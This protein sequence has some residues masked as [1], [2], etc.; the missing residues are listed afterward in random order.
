MSGFAVACDQRAE[1]RIRV[2]LDGLKVI[3]AHLIATRS[4]TSPRSSTPRGESH[5][6][7]SATASRRRGGGGCRTDRDP[8]PWAPAHSAAE[9][10]LR[11]AMQ[12]RSCRHRI[13]GGR[14]DEEPLG[15][16]SPGAGGADGV[17]S[18]AVG[19][20]ADGR[21]ATENT[22]HSPGETARAAAVECD[23]KLPAKA[24]GAKAS[25]SARLAD[26]RWVRAA[27]KGECIRAKTPP[28]G[29]EYCLLTC[30]AGCGAANGDQISW[31]RT[32]RAR[33]HRCRQP[34]PPGPG[35]RRGG[36]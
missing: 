5:P 11:Q 29:D 21:R 7:R 26:P 20:E 30:G 34:S 24:M 14:G 1:P 31:R 10:E 35:S 2:K 9:L 18:T 12:G 3:R 28:S 4:A 19:R 16:A 36:G 6:A 23:E 22:R 8:A 17:V 13:P 25:P 27:V 33:R 32:R 15:C